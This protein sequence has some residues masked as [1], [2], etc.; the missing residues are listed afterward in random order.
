[1]GAVNKLV[2]PID[3]ESLIRRTA[4]TLLDFSDVKPVVV[5]G[6]EADNI[7]SVL[8]DLPL[9]IVKNEHYKTFDT[10]NSLHTGSL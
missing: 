6:H 1:M 7:M 10:H 8:N 5:V 3:G 4:K 2:L 9:I